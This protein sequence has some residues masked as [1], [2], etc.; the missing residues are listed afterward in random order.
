MPDGHLWLLSQREAW[1]FNFISSMIA[2][3]LGLSLCL[4]HWYERPNLSS[5]AY[6]NYRRKGILNDISGLNAYLLSVISQ[7][8]FVLAVWSGSF[9]LHAKYKI[10]PDTN[11]IWILIVV[12]MFLEQWKTIRRVFRKRSNKALI[13][14]A[15]I[16]VTGSF[17][18]AFWAPLDLKEVDKNLIS[19]SIEHNYPFHPVNSTQTEGITRRS[20]ITD[21]HLLYPRG[22]S[23]D[24]SVMPDL[25]TSMDKHFRFEEINDLVAT[26][27]EIMDPLDYNEHTFLIH[28]DSKM[29]LV[30]IK[31]AHNELLK[32]GIKRIF[33]SSLPMSSTDLYKSGQVFGIQ[34]QSNYELQDQKIS[35]QANSDTIMIEVMNSNSIFI[36]NREVSISQ[37][38]MEIQ[39]YN[40][41]YDNWNIMVSYSDSI[42]FQDYIKIREKITETIRVK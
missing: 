41:I 12:V 39:N 20:L 3:S 21:L 1:F 10:Y 37:F 34:I 13:I 42:T 31:K 32:C 7:L 22:Q 23:P 25:F 2:S 17:I 35:Q 38:E 9:S 16:S 4:K 19:N 15:I 24:P 36:N 6:F 40:G 11:F 26:E 5:D 14:T 33:Y 27:R 18:F 8:L 30:H 28:T 29:P